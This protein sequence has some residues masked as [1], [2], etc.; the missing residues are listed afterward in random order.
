[1]INITHSEEIILSRSHNGSGLSKKVYAIC[2]KALFS[3]DNESDREF[4][5]RI[6]KEAQR[7]FGRM[8]KDNPEM[9][10]DKSWSGEIGEEVSRFITTQKLNRQLSN[11]PKKIVNMYDGGDIKYIEN[12]QEK[13]INVSS[14]KLSP[15]DNLT[16]FIS[17]PNDYFGLI[18][19]QQMTHQY[20]KAAEAHFVF[21]LYENGKI[22]RGVN[23]GEGI[24]I[25]VPYSVKWVAPGFL[26]S[27][28]LKRMMEDKFLP[29]KKN[30]EI[31]KG[32]YGNLPYN[33][34]MYTD[35]IVIPVSLL[36]RFVVNG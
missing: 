32:I 25:D 8:H 20:L 34:K 30:G 2:G 21:L 9:R 3:L 1:M 12:K 29:L 28:D 23:I 26:T 10:F 27:Q 31:L 15:R 33:I 35:N 36:R 5:L 16:N 11:E 17:S 18:P 6:Y 14:R 19:L 22:I 24:T 13:V 7:K 4:L